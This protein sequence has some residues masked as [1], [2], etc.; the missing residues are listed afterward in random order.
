MLLSKPRLRAIAFSLGALAAVAT[1]ASCQV[2]PLYGGAEG[3]ALN[4][5][6]HELAFSVPTTQVAQYVRNELIFLTGGGAGESI[7]A[8]YDVNLSAFSVTSELLQDDSSDTARAGRTIVTADFALRR[9]EDNKLLAS[10]RRQAT[11]LL[12]FPSQEFAKLRA[13]RDG[14]QRASKEVAEIINAD[15]AI[16]LSKEPPLEL[17]KQ[18][19]K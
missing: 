5:K 3:T 8:K 6:M 1:L 19:V 2:R 10:G 11:A 15:L 13:I 4:A 14:E 9:R 7:N 12:D 17:P 18:P 16:A